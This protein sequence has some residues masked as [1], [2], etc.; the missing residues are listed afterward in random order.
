[1]LQVSRGGWVGG[2]EVDLRRR[3]AGDDD[4]DGL[5]LDPAVLLRQRVE[6]REAYRRREQLARQARDE[7]VGEETLRFGATA[8]FLRRQDVPDFAARNFGCEQTVEVT[9]ASQDGAQADRL[10]DLGL[11]FGDLD[12]FR[13]EGT[14]GARP[15]GGSA[16][17]GHVCDGR[18]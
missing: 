15:V 5:E 1:M 17:L 10:T 14:D 8:A 12:R 3:G 6:G 11:I 7:R 18:R 13:D 16:A 4:F 9:R 2:D